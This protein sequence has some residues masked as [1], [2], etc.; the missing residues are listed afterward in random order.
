MPTGYAGMM[1][2]AYLPAL[3]FAVMDR[4]VAEHYGGDIQRANIQPGH[5]ARMLSKFPMPP[6][7]V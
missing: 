5:E 2:L 4:R 7:P 1:V 6:A 3:W